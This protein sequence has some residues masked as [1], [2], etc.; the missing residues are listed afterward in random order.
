MKQQSVAIIAA[1]ALFGCA[2]EEKAKRTLPL[3]RTVEVQQAPLRNEVRY[4]ASVLPDKQ[5]ELAFRVGGFVDAIKQ[6]G[7]M[8]G[9]VHSIEPGDPVRMGETLAQVQ[10]ADYRARVE[11]AQGQQSEAESARMVAAAQVEESK[12]SEQQARLDHDRAKRL[13][14]REALTKPE[15]DTAIARLEAAQ[16]RTKAT[17]AQIVT[18]QAQISTAA[19]AHKQSVVPLSE[20]AIVAPFGGIVLARKIEIGSLVAPGTPA[21]TIADFSAVRIA[22]GVPDIA[23]RNFPHGAQMDVTVEALPGAHFR[24]SVRTIAPSADPTNRVFTVELSIP[25]TELRLKPGMVASVAA[26][27]DGPARLAPVIPMSALVRSQL[28]KS[29]Y[30]VYVL[31]NAGGKTVVRFRPVIIGQTVGNGVEVKDGLPVAARV[32]ATGGLQ[33]AD[34]EE[35]RELSQEGSGSVA[36]NR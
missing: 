35:V 5:V 26:P 2:K 14:D 17:E 4:S 33:L 25:N 36:Q 29:E 34:G 22:F 15:L 18:A 24:G 13:F 30:G 10:V 1:L 8:R 7:G 9:R 6:V 16:A 32:V 31:E 28:G 23:L 19:A 3:V 27:P 11:Q 12:A 20:T 21:F